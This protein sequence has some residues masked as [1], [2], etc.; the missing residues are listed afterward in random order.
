MTGKPPANTG[1]CAKAALNTTLLPALKAP[2]VKKILADKG[3]EP[4]KYERIFQAFG[5]KPHW[6]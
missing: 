6:T 2:K 3:I 5:R 4:N 1:K